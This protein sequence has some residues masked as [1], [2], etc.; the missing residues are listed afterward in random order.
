MAW[1]DFLISEITS[2]EGVRRPPNHVTM[3]YAIVAISFVISVG[4]SEKM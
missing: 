1:R 2:S 3:M 4:Y